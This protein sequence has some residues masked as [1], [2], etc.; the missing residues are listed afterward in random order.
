MGLPAK[1][2]WLDTVSYAY[3]GKNMREWYF[4]NFRK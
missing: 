1:V 3:D 4:E 2:D